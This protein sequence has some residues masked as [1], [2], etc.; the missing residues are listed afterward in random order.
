VGVATL[1]GSHISAAAA[2]LNSAAMGSAAYSQR[3]FRFLAILSLVIP[4][5]YLVD[6]AVGRPHFDTIALRLTAFL[7]AIPLIFADKPPLRGAR[8]LHIYFVLLVTNAL[9]FTYGA[10]LVGNAAAS[11]AGTEIDILWV[12]QYIIA[13]FLF[14]QLI[15]NGL[16][17]CVLWIVSSIAAGFPILIVDE[18]NWDELKRVLLYPVTGYVTAILFGIVTNRNVDYVNSEKLKAAAAIGSNI[19]HELRTPLAS[20]QLLTRSLRTQTATLMRG[21]SKAV[22]HGL[23]EEMLSQAQ[24][25]GLDRALKLIEQEVAY[26]NTVI[27]M[28][29]LN[30]SDNTERDAELKRFPISDC[31]LEA[32]HRYPFNNSKEKELIRLDVVRPFPVEAPRL[33]LVH[34][35]FNLIKNCVFYAQRSKE[36]LVTITIGE[37]PKTNSLSITDNGPGIPTSIR[38]HVFDR[39]YTTTRSGQGAGV[40]LSFCKTVMESIGGSID[41][42]SV[43]GEYTTF[44]LTF[45][46]VNDDQRHDRRS[47]LAAD[48]P[49]VD[50]R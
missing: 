12:L 23:Q 38:R 18:V 40:G 47:R 50:D 3:H 30:T 35:L 1:I 46:P 2:H 44:R 4:L 11:P 48:S 9:P 36:P 37:A 19:A 32:I 24:T 39:F 28:L 27:D 5:A 31:V 13:L 16:L 21:Y 29:L 8:Y 41:C 25:K 43:E 33:L 6:V 26:S 7:A 17:A 20:I 42:E 14:I 34:V 10:M 49:S 22:K 45:P 15:H